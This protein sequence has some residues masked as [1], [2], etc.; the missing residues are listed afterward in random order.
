MG[1]VIGSEPPF[2]VIRPKPDQD[3]ISQGF[4]GT[5]HADPEVSGNL[6]EATRRSWNKTA[7]VFNEV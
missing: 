3:S 7:A 6:M 2:S 1:D 5:C 4:P